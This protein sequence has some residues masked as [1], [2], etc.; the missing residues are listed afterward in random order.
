MVTK[1]LKFIRKSKLTL[2]DHFVRCLG[3]CAVLACFLFVISLEKI[4]RYPRDNSELK[5][6]AKRAYDHM[7]T[8]S[9]QF[10]YRLPWHE[11]RRKAG[12]YIENTLRSYGYLPKDMLFSEVIGGVRYQDLRNIYVEKH[13]TSKPNEI[14]MVLAHY[15]T[16]D[17]T[18]EGAMDDASGVGV[19]LEL[20][21]IFSKIDTDRTIL[22]LLTDSE[23]FG[24]FWG[25]TQ[26]AD[27]YA[28]KDQIIAAASFDFVAIKKQKAIVTLCDGLKS[29]YTPLWLRELALDS[30]RES[31]AI[32]IVDFQNVME[33]VSRAI[34]IPAADHGAL[35]RAGIPAFNWAGQ[36]DDFSEQM[37]K[38][39]HTPEDKADYMEVASFEQYGKAA[40]RLVKSIDLIREMPKNF[41]SGSYWKITNELYLQGWVVAILHILVF[42]PFVFFSVLKFALMFQKYPRTQI[43][44]VCQHEA[45]NLGILFGS[46][47]IGYLVLRLLPALRVMD[48]YESYPATQKSSLLYNPNFLA[49][50]LVVA[51]IIIVYFIFKKIFR[52]LEDIPHFAEIRHCVHAGFLTLVIVLAYFGNSSLAVL[53]LAPPA[54]SWAFVRSRETGSG[55]ILNTLLLLGGSVTFLAMIIVMTTVFHVGIVYWYMF[56]SAAYGLFSVYSVVLFALAI[57]IMLR[58]FR[59]F[60]FHKS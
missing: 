56:L 44:R 45:K 42:I 28:R 13:G 49:I 14:I 36:N 58:L 18:V 2:W 6:D 20:A 55:R 51:A 27:H 34:Q 29:G 5:F 57:A 41:R 12:K 10:P 60:V 9:K 43:I 59:S 33:F 24:A 47:M 37:A 21:R 17:T 52:E 53:L 46:F 23:E 7:W 40:E 50:L 30:L 25:A 31:G 11:N 16:A 48:Q 35:L 4:D 19:V 26:F 54:Y 22:F 39:H 38:Y 1:S 3:V 8:I 15:D 32:E